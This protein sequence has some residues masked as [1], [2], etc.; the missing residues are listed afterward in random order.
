MFPEF[1]ISP[2]DDQSILIKTLRCQPAVMFRTTTTQKR[3]THG[4]TVSLSM[5]HVS[6]YNIIVVKKSSNPD[7]YGGKK[8]IIIIIPA[9]Y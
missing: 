6:L 8:K 5:Y 7:R 1:N 3:L 4:T 2:E 9:K